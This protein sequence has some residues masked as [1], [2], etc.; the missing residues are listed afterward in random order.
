[1]P[2]P[3]C[4]RAA[5]ETTNIAARVERRRDVVFIAISHVEFRKPRSRRACRRTA[6]ECYAAKELRA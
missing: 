3:D 5:P 4:A 2:G 6:C 1:M